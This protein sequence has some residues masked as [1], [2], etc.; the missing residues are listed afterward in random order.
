M[1]AILLAIC[2]ATPPIG[3]D[4]PAKPRLNRNTLPQDAAVLPTLSHNDVENKTCEALEKTVEAQRVVIDSF[5]AGLKSL[6]DR[7]NSCL[8]SSGQVASKNA[9][10]VA[11]EAAILEKEQRLGHM[12]TAL[13]SRK[14]VLDERL[15]A[16]EKREKVLKK[17]GCAAKASPST[18]ARVAGVCERC[19]MGGCAEG[20]TCRDGVCERTGAGKKIVCTK[21][22]ICGEGQ[23][24]VCRRL[25]EE[26]FEGTG[27][28][29]MLK[30]NLEMRGFFVGT[31][32]GI[33]GC[34]MG[35]IRFD[36]SQRKKI[37]GKVFCLEQTLE[38]CKK[39]GLEIVDD[40]PL[41]DLVV[42]RQVVGRQ[43][44]PSSSANTC[45]VVFGPLDCYQ[46][47][48]CRCRKA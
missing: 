37:C 3:D 8:A 44:L 6:S 5:Q 13:D 30:K 46:R 34:V 42:G 24:R 33:K 21:G 31:T 1:L 17:K 40:V 26:F 27:E 7:L 45:C 22:E 25:K 9:T 14:I 18:N 2:R 10:L 29:R 23:R 35:K 41:G 20:L 28:G 36:C 19:G 38:E 15:A 47:E 39:E 12:E 11:K 48:L 43:A 4:P 16:I 32:D